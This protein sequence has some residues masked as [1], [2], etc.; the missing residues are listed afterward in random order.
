M[1]KL[2]KVRKRQSFR[3]PGSKKTLQNM[4]QTSPFPQHCHFAGSVIL[5]FFTVI[6]VVEGLGKPHK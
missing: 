2:E 1:K 3:Q 6:P 5:L 4:E